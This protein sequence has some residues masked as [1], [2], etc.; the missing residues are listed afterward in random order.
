VEKMS[1]LEPLWIMTY[2]EMKRFIRAKS[3]LIGSI[4]NPLIWAIFFGMGWANAFNFP[5]AKLIFGGVDYLT[6]LMPGIVMM[7]V[8]TASFISGVTVIWDRQFGF[9]K[10]VL[11]APAPR[12]PIAIGRALGG[13]LMA[14]L[15]GLLVLVAMIPLVNKVKL[16][17][18]LPVILV[19]L[20]IG[21]SFSSV[22][23]ALAI[24]ISSMEGFH[25][26]SSFLMMPT[27]FLSG[28]FYPINTM[29]KWMKALAYANP[30]TYG[31]DLTRYYLVGISDFSM[32]RDFIV[33]LIL[34]GLALGVA[35]YEFKHA[36]IE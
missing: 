1:W 35:A 33:L 23:I 19:G 32:A 21:L 7:T 30:L 29:P 9:L 34:T 31:V 4:V 22:G 27:I 3:R 17:G 8:F 5:Q 13:S 2:R 10:E 26:I 28:A 36:T 14:V 20:L 24:R 6:Y 11:V 16:E 25:I 12:E 18:I 15:Q